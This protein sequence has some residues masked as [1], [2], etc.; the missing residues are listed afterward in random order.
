[1][2]KKKKNHHFVVV[3]KV[4]LWKPLA[5]LCCQPST[6]VTETEPVSLHLKVNDKYG[7]I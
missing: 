4:L 3:Q 6:D 2:Y 1:M 7:I 5:V